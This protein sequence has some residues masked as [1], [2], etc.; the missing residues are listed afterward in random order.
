VADDGGGVPLDDVVRDA[1]MPVRLVPGTH[2]GP[3]AARN[4]GAAVAR[5]Q[6]LAFIDDDCTAEDGWL[7]ALASRLDDGP[8]VVGGRVL[9][10]LPENQYARAGQTLLGFLYRYYHEDQNGLTPFFTTNNLA[11][12]R[13]DFDSVGGFDPSFEFA[14]EDRD[15]SERCRDRGLALVYAPE[16]EVRH[17][18]P[19]TLRSFLQQHLSYGEGAWRFHQVRREQRGRAVA[20]EPLRF[21]ARMMAA[22]FVERDPTPVRQA[23]LILATQAVA[24][25]GFARAARRERRTS[26]RAARSR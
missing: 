3:A 19:L 17:A 6:V 5:G 4:R 12:R 8:A 23:M 1:G 16:A 21:Y 18:R 20:V 15:F 14:S 25:I 10:G 9:N 13:D 2:G 24:A 7:A 11:I 26:A 22:P